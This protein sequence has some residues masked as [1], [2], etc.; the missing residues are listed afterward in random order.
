MDIE[1]IGEKTTVSTKAGTQPIP[2][3]VVMSD[4]SL[5]VQAPQIPLVELH[6]VLLQAAS[7]LTERTVQRASAMERVLL[8]VH[9]RFDGFDD[10]TAQS[11][12]AVLG[13]RG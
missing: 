8:S 3:C 6:R 1:G 11:M 5:K 4:G 12:A 9:Q 2:V 7:I 10:E 13:A